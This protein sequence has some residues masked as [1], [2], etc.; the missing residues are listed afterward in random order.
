MASDDPGFV[1]ARTAELQQLTE[2]LALALDVPPDTLPPPQLDWVQSK[3][4][5]EWPVWVGVAVFG[6]A[7]ASC[8]LIYVYSWW[9]KL[10]SK[11]LHVQ[12]KRVEAT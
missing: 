8:T 1:A 9:T 7:L 11:S 2:R 3:P 4:R 6:L 5:R 10:L 12:K